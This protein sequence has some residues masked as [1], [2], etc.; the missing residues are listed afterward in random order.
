MQILSQTYTHS[1]FHIHYAS[2]LLLLLYVYIS[3]KA[4]SWRVEVLYKSA[5]LLFKLIVITFV[6]GT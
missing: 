2:L 5:L 4:L 1:H 6:C 3:G